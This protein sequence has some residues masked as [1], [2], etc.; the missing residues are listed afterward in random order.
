MWFAG[1]QSCVAILRA[2][3]NFIKSFTTGA[4]SRPPV[5]ASAPFCSHKRSTGQTLRTHTTT[6]SLHKAALTGGQK[7]SWKSTTIKA[8]LNDPIL[9]LSCEE[10]ASTVL[11]SHELKV[12]V[13]NQ[14]MP[15]LWGRRSETLYSWIPNP[16]PTLLQH[17]IIS[18]AASSTSTIS[19]IVPT[20]KTKK[21]FPNIIHILTILSHNTGNSLLSFT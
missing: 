10:Q 16:P 17:P 9:R 3:G 4:M 14:I 8:G 12:Q 18:G 5:T 6:L 21:L 20:Y 2:N 1:C 19:Q 13:S 7:S 15:H 11:A